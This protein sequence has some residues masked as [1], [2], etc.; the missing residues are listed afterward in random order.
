[1]RI[2][3]QI[4][5]IDCG[6]CVVEAMHHFYF[7]K[8]TAIDE[9]RKEANITER[10][11]NIQ[12]LID[13]GGRFGIRIEAFNADFSSVNEAATTHMIAIIE[14]D[15]LTHYIIFIKKKKTY[16]IYDPAIGEYDLTETEFEEM[17][18][19][20]VL[21]LEKIETKC[22]A[23]TITSVWWLLRVN[24]HIIIWIF[25]CMLIGIIFAFV[26][27]VFSKLVFDL[28]IPGFLNET[29]KLLVISFSF[30]SILRVL[31]L[32]LRNLLGRKLELIIEFDLCSLYIKKIKTG[33][34]KHLNKFSK[35][36]FLRRYF[37]IN[38]TSSFVASGLFLIVNEI[39]V[40]AISVALLFWI[41][42]TLFV[43]ALLFGVIIAIVTYVFQFFLKHKYTTIIK[44]QM[45]CFSS[46]NDL[47]CEL[48]SIKEDNFYKY[49]KNNFDN[50]YSNFKKNEHSAWKLISIQKSIIELVN[51]IA[52]IALTYLSVKMIFESKLTVGS[53]LM[54]IGLFNTYISPLVQLC[55]FSMS[56]HQ[57][58]RNAEQVMAIIGIDDEYDNTCGLKLENIDSIK[59]KN[60][61]F[62]FDKQI[63]DIN[64][65]VINQSLQISGR[66]GI[67]K[68]TLL[69]LIACRYQ[70]EAIYFNNIE[71]SYYSNES[72]RSFTYLS[73]INQDLPADKV[74]NIITL[75]NQ[76]A[77]LRFNQNI[78]KYD[79]HT[80]LRKLDIKL[81]SR[82][83]SG[84]NNLS[85]GQRQIIKLLR[86][87]A[88]EW[89]LIILDE[90]FENIDKDSYEFLANAIDA[91][92]PKTIFIETS[93]A[94]R[95]VRKVAE[96]AFEA[97]N[98]N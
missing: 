58:K 56:Y 49:L 71:A 7:G 21:T 88:F 83:I 34:L 3:K 70:S 80:L 27:T 9:I 25:A 89:K 29:L 42:A 77:L 81:D 2:K 32:W 43:V 18:K 44:N 96:V 73:S 53:M 45:H 39:I 66:N 72:I 54:F 82:V 79:L 20:M 50:S 46:I 91:E 10:G 85:S 64:E 86:L 74:I 75:G 6:L 47:T 33:D 69:N 68:S 40:F 93:H 60:L 28:V 78:K 61:K 98:K 94:K 31:N 38:S 84:G 11:M 67:G 1:M 36:E 97:I 62:G 52:P 15:G 13:L 14:K 90:A 12:S 30:I 55:I 92:Y 48:S 41:S 51:L 37:L 59:I 5:N 65:L 24:P 4:T 26:S 63:I 17:Y 87:F 95:Y 19:G 76:A 8:S 35:Q 23:K 57:N 22:K 16:Q